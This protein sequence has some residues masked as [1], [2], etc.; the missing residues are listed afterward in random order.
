LTIEYWNRQIERWVDV[1]SVDEPDLIGLE[2]VKEFDNLAENFYS[3]YT[4]D[5]N[6][7]TESEIQ[8][9]FI[10]AG[11]R[12]EVKFVLERSYPTDRPTVMKG[13]G[14]KVESVPVSVFDKTVGSNLT[15]D[16]ER[17]IT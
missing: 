1:F 4:D 14:R 3:N 13:T 16:S 12:E 11:V 10:V 2:L 6:D 15:F 17:E 5:F 9:G 8:L 7:Y